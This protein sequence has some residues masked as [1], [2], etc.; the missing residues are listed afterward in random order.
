[1]RLF[2]RINLPR[3]DSK[4][5]V[6]FL[7]RLGSGWPFWPTMT[8]RLLCWTTGPRLTDFDRTRTTGWSLRLP[9]FLL[10]GWSVE[11]SEYTVPPQIKPFSNKEQK[12]TERIRSLC[13]SRKHAQMD[14]IIIWPYSDIIIT[15]ECGPLCGPLIYVKPIILLRRYYTSAIIADCNL[16]FMHAVSL[17][18]PSQILTCR[19][20]NETRSLAIADLSSYSAGA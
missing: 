17:T 8:H 15:W 10:Q 4:C 11:F 6:T 12:C 19:R 9:S 5:W 1:M 2:I 18:R 3:D 16:S 13:I 7:G 20:R 14:L